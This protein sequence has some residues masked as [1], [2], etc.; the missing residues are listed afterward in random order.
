MLSPQ[1][2]NNNIQKFFIF[3]IVYFF[4]IPQENWECT[5]QNFCFCF[6]TDL[7]WWKLMI[8]LMWS[9]Q[10]TLDKYW[11]LCMKSD[12]NELNNTMNKLTNK[13]V[14]ESKLRSMSSILNNSIHLLLLFILL[15]IVFIEW[16]DL[17]SEVNK[18]F[19]LNQI[20]LR[21]E[22]KKKW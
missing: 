6:C 19:I 21:Y 17:F 3:E 5:A 10:I 14:A 13:H 15:F 11:F 22:K 20:Y 16:L 7:D 8:Y 1:K 12:R 2:T 4:L 18:H 9:F